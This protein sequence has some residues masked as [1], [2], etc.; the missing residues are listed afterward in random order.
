MNAQ[1]IVDASSCDFR[2][3]IIRSDLFSHQTNSD[4]EQAYV[5]ASFLGMPSVLLNCVIYLRL[6]LNLPTSGDVK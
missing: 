1:L 6:K 5:V 3:K 4:T 2:N